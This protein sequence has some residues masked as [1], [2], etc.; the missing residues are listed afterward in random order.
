MMRGDQMLGLNNN[1]IKK[2]M[3]VGDQISNRNK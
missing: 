3:K 1:N 2:T